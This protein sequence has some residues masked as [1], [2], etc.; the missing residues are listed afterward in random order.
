MSLEM[1]E[2]EK[3]K[4]QRAEKGFHQVLGRIRQEP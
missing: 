4:E 3:G 1:L 2:E